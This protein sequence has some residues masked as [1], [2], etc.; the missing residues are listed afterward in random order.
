MSRSLKKDFAHL[1][2][3]EKKKVVDFQKKKYILFLKQNIRF[4]SAQNL[5]N[6]VNFITLFCNDEQ[7]LFSCLFFHY[8]FSFALSCQK[9]SLFL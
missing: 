6:N 8:E 9:T 1:H 2:S 4:S 7:C 5:E 3:K